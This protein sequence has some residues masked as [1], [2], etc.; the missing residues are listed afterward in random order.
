MSDMPRPRHLHHGRMVW[1]V[2]VGKGPRI[3]ILGEYGSPEFMAAYEAAVA[4]NPMTVPG[5][6]PKAARVSTIRC[7]GCGTSTRRLPSGRGRTL[8]RPAP[9]ISLRKERACALF[10]PIPYSMAPNCST[11]SIQKT[12]LV[13]AKLVRIRSISSSALARGSTICAMV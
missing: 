4:G 1:Y 12:S 10:A 9:V 6:R 13:P 2:H 7:N 8:R 11:G 5:T 3:R